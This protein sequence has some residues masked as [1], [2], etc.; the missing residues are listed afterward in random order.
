M[1]TRIWVIFC[2]AAL[3]TACKES[4]DNMEKKLEKMERLCLEER[5]E[6]AVDLPS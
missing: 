2:V 3:L 4:S 6:E 5:Y 1:K